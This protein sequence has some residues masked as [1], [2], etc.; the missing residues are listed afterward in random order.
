MAKKIKDM[1]VVAGTEDMLMGKPHLD[2]AIEG[3]PEI[4]TLLLSHCPD[5]AE[6]IVANQVDLQISGHSHGGQ[7]RFPLLGAL[8]TPPGGQIYIDGLYPL[9]QTNVY[10]NSRAYRLIP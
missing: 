8:I 10:V 4:C 5:F 7:I 9:T 2:Q 3:A 1:L 6:N